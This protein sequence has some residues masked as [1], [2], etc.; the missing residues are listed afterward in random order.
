MTTPQIGSIYQT[1]E[2]KYIWFTDSGTD[3]LGE[4]FFGVSFY[5]TFQTINT[6]YRASDR[7]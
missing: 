1:E 7:D 3:E 4:Y 5:S 6:C 2:G